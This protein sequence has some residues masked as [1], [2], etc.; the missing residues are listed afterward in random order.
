M[1]RRDIMAESLRQL[2]NNKAISINDE[3]LEKFRWS[4]GAWRPFPDTNAALEYLQE[5]YKLIILSNID[6]ETMR[7]TLA[8]FSVKFDAVYTAEDIGTYK[9]DAYNFK[10]LWEKCKED[11]EIDYEKGELLHVARSLYADHVTCKKLG[12]RS[13]WISREGKGE[14]EAEPFKGNVAYE[15]EFETMGRLLRK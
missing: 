9:P 12:M 11:L 1:L 2:A 6:N 7:S 15:W 8:H 4:G 5:Q 13:V 10:Y 3:E 14:E